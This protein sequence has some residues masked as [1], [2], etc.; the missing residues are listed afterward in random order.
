M[1]AR[2]CN[3]IFDINLALS[4]MHEVVS[5][6]KILK[7][8]RG[9]KPKRKISVYALIIALKEYDERT[10]REQKRKLLN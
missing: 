3:E 7:K 9:A 8:G 4:K 5:R 10:L 6:S 2:W 1:L